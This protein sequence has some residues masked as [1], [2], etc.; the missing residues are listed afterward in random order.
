VG[1]GEV[2]EIEKMADATDECWSRDEEQFSYD[3]LG[4][5]LDNHDDLDVGDTVYTGVAETPDPAEWVDADDIIEQLA[6]R[7]GDDCGEFADDYPDVSKEA[8]L[9]LQR[10]LE[11][12]A[13]KHCTP[14]WYMVKNVR[15]HEITAEDLAEA[16]TS[17][18]ATIVSLETPLD[19]E[20]PAAADSAA[21]RT[22]GTIES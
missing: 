10:L 11:S 13:R 18:G 5:L 1:T 9:E 3:T 6:C 4:E 22:D 14:T 15:E 19:K 17:T 16:D 2:S 12:W 8:K 7:A 21:R 20:P